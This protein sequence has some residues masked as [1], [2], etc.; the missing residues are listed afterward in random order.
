MPVA[1]REILATLS[2]QGIAPAGPRF[3]HHLK[4]SETGA[5]TYMHPLDTPMAETGGPF[6][7]LT[8]APVGRTAVLVQPW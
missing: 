6:R 4:T 8:P 5:R 2:G 3:D 1:I 7:P